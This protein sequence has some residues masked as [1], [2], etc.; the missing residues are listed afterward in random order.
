MEPKTVEK[1]EIVLVGMVFYGD[2]FRNQSSW[3][4]EN[5]I[6]KLWKRFAAKEKTIKNKVKNEDTKSTLNQRSIRKPRI[7][8]CL[9]E[10]R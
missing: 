4:Q 6:G 1:D 8:M 7:T 2:P 10:S 5:E 3:S 9:W